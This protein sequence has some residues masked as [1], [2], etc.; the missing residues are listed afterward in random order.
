MTGLR[1]KSDATSGNG[2][3]SSSASGGVRDAR[4]EATEQPSERPQKITGAPCRRSVR[5]K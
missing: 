3:S 1:A 4:Y 5:L 2:L